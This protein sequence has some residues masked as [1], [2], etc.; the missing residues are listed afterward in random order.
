MAKKR[1][2]DDA[3]LSIVQRYEKDAS[4]YTWGQLGTER[5][6]A[7]K[8]YYREP[9]GNEEE[10]HSEIV[11]SEVQDTVEWILPSLLKIFSSTDNISPVLYLVQFFLFLYVLVGHK[12]V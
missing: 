1:M 9:Y 6:K 3:I 5:E 2:D 7:M 8:E 11:T 12:N 10:G 4:A